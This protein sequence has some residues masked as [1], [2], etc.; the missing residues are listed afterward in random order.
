[1]TARR[2]SNRAFV[3]T[4]LATGPVTPLPGG[5]F[6]VGG[7]H[8]YGAKDMYSVTVHIQDVDGSK[9]DAVATVGVT[10]K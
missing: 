7:S 3:L 4:A 9:A 5:G 10:T 1:M 6:A 2:R 8:R